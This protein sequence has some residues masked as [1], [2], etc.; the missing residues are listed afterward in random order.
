VEEPPTAPRAGPL[1]GVAVVF[2]GL[3]TEAGLIVMAVADIDPVERI[4]GTGGGSGRAD[5]LPLA[6]AGHGAPLDALVG[7]GMGLGLVGLT[8]LVRNVKALRQLRNELEGMLGAQTSGSIAILAVTSA[9]GEELL[10]RGAL[11][12]LIGFWPTAVLFGVLH[13]GHSPKL[14]LWAL[15]ALLAGVLLGWLADYTG[16]LLAPVLAHLTV[17]YWNLHALVPRAPAGE[18]AA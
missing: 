17:N 14:W 15:F 2:Y 11:H 3:M 5:G 13:G 9:I 8:W 10:F 18:H 7:V 1:V 12:P 4:F 16:N 6:G